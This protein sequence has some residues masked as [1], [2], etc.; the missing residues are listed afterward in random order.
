MNY[1]I[2]IS[3]LCLMGV[4]FSCEYDSTIT[5]EEIEITI[6]NN[7]IVTINIPKAIGTNEAST[8]INNALE[9]IISSTLRIGNVD[10]ILVE[11]LE[12]NIRLFNDEFQSFKNDFPESL[13]EWEAQ[14]DGDIMYQSP[15]VIS[16]AITSYINTGGAHGALTIRLINFNAEDGL[17]IPNTALFTKNDVLESIAK[18]YF[19]E[20]IKDKGDDFFNTSE[21]KLSDNIGYDEEGI[22]MLY[23]VFEI[24]PYSTGITQFTIP[25]EDISHLLNFN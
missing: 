2:A 10:S 7:K 11:T 8:K 16:I 9:T 21:F 25:Y 24:A 15:E 4:F 14:I 5:F 6:P 23:N 18:P 17:Q 12:G 22:I 20:M 3:M 13:Q 1:K 19:D